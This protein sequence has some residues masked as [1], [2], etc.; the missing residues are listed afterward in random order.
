MRWFCANSFYPLGGP[1]GADGI[2]KCVVP[3][4]K[5]SGNPS[6]SGYEQV[7]GIGERPGEQFS[8]LNVLHQVEHGK[9]LERLLAPEY[10][11]I[12]LDMDRRFAEA[13]RFKFRAAV[14]A[15]KEKKSR[16]S[17]DE[18]KRR[19]ESGVISISSKSRHAIEDVLL[20]HSTEKPSSF[21]PPNS[22][23]TF[24]DEGVAG[25]GSGMKSSVQD[26]DGSVE[27]ANAAR[28]DIEM[29]LTSLGFSELDAEAAS[30]RF[31]SV[32][33]ALDFLCLN[34]DEAELPESFASRADVEVVQYVDS[35]DENGLRRTDIVLAE[36]ISGLFG[37]SRFAVERALRSACG[38]HAMTIQAVYRSLTGASEAGPQSRPPEL[39]SEAAVQK[40]SEMQVLE[41]I[42]GCEVQI[43]AV[44][45]CFPELWAAKV[46]I[47][48]GLKALNIRTPVTVYVVDCSK[49]YPFSAPVVCLGEECRELTKAKRRAAIRAAAA[50]ISRVRGHDQLS[51]APIHVVHAVASFL[52]G[53]TE[54]E[55]M[56]AVR[57]S[58]VEFPSRSTNVNHRRIS[59]EALQA[60]HGNGGEKQTGFS[61]K[62]EKSS[63]NER[64]R[65]SRA[66]GGKLSN[67]SLPL[68]ATSP[69]QYASARQDESRKGNFL[70][71]R[72]LLPAHGCREQL[73][74]CISGSRV[75]IV[76]GTTGS[77]KTTQVPQFILE[78][79][80]AERRP[81]SVICTQPRR[82]AAISVALRVADEIGESVGG[83]IGYQVKL[84]TKRSK[85]TKLLFCTTGVLIRRLQSDPLLEE[86]TH[87]IV[88]ECHE[89]SVETDFMFLLL[90]DIL[91]QRPTLR[92]IVMSATLD[93]ER[94]GTYFS[95]VTGTSSPVISIPGRTY[96][97]KEQYLEDAVAFSGYEGVASAKNFKKGMNN[98][99][100]NREIQGIVKVEGAVNTHCAPDEQRTPSATAGHRPSSSASRTMQKQD[101]QGSFSSPSSI[102]PGNEDK[103]Q[104]MFGSDQNP[105]MSALTS[106]VL[107][108]FDES[109][110]NVD[111]I[112][113][114]VR[115]LHRE[116]HDQR[117]GAILVFL[118]GI[119]DIS[120]LLE[121]LS[122]GR[123]SEGIYVLP[124][125]SAL[126][127]VD[128]AKVFAS[129]PK[130]CRKVICS[131]NIAETSVTVDDVTMVIDSVRVKEM[132]YDEL[133]GTSVLKETFVSRAA[134]RQRAGR[135]GRVREGLC[136]HLVRRSTFDTKLADHQEPEIRRVSI[137]GLILNVL[138]LRSEHAHC[139]SPQEFLRKALDPPRPEAVAAALKNLRAIGALDSVD[140]ASS[141]AEENRSPEQ[142]VSLS[143]L[144][145][146]LAGLPLDARLG[147]LLVYGAL[148]GCLESALTIAAT[149]SERSPFVFPFEKRESARAAMKH[150]KWGHSDLLMFVKVYDAWRNVEHAEGRRGT[151]ASFCDQN[152][153]S[154]KTLMAISGI[155]AQFANMLRDAGFSDDLVSRNFNHDIKV[156][157][158]VICAALYPNVVR[159]DMPKTVYQ[160]TISGAIPRA[161][162]ANELRL[163]SRS[164]E[165]V[166]FHPQSINFDE[167]DFP[168][169]WVAYFCKVKTSKVFLR[170]GTA[171]SPQAILLFGGAIQV[172]HTEQS[173]SVDGWINFKAPA[174]IA[175]L[176][177]ELRQR[178]DALLLRKFH[179]PNIDIQIEGRALTDAVLSLI[180]DEL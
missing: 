171:V 41:A 128:Q 155:R 111:L 56:Q 140:R 19:A 57:K 149:L 160:G 164:N 148:F 106:D 34:L 66:I 175:V 99:Q 15:E 115:K 75:T 52:S 12:W 104:D 2:M 133:N 112:E 147:K 20:A 154:R 22:A 11:E 10:R 5:R 113:A 69:A 4:G 14:V 94:L 142:K 92:L 165:R 103:A 91:L 73:L 90:R 44:L 143:A 83:Q 169:R 55:L 144:G 74:H 37:V 107:K 131:T 58:R 35:L 132:A 46:K 136:F 18:A 25:T 6:S 30:V 65:N 158:A 21:A 156:V 116:T 29:R 179:S 81:V 8:A 151:K 139:H 88:D 141:D 23:D 76:T 119:A 45:P 3:A 178:L 67:R 134:A 28:S 163:R 159:I 70:E 100:L 152:F 63:G 36:R 98:E 50:E 43:G 71:K 24:C 26:D 153:L 77:G 118:P 105:G 62:I 117:R 38:D 47:S 51:D 84:N 166:F 125:H 109:V 13:E 27:Q 16:A 68:S 79:A 101:Q 174:R 135:A 102:T 33:E 137:E 97:V 157:K 60:V 96:A 173:L 42:Y 39:L 64:V 54:N 53:S 167:A 80:E 124:L 108:S 72:K 150:F 86:L 114:L 48:A 145:R 89:R 40:E 146:H 93:T 130:S 127:P 161:A 78:E 110:V 177:R 59:P 170:D 32:D 121:R 85:F 168:S 1:R 176:V 123:D 49:L 180:R 7:I 122:R 126:S 9:P 61:G 82:I 138:S 17:R 95:V 129:P 172:Q 87:V 120:I 162:K 31:P